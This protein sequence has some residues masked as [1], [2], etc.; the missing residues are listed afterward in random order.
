[1]T[2]LTLEEAQSH[3]CRDDEHELMVSI[4]TD[5]DEE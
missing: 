1:M 5:D 4:S 3:C 2:G